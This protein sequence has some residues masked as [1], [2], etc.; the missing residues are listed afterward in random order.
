MNEEKERIMGRSY[1][2]SKV[3]ACLRQVSRLIRLLEDLTL[4]S[5]VESG[6]ITINNAEFAL[7][8]TIK[9]SIGMLQNK[10]DAKGVM[11]E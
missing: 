5:K 8:T 9:N 10:F 4:L 2:V 1:S 11:L 3:D 7:N 6:E